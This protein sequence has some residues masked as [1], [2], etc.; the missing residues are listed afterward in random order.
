MKRLKE[1]LPT[2][3]KTATRGT[4]RAFLVYY[5]LYFIIGETITTLY[6]EI[7]SVH[8]SLCS[9]NLCIKLTNPSFKIANIK[10]HP[11]TE[12]S[13]TNVLF[14]NDVIML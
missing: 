12:T 1:E 4:R 6:H 8:V 5:P 10:L 11:F 7:I 14:Y 13:K 9:I 3:L 2:L